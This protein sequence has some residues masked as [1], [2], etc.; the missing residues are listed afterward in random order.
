M[1][2]GFGKDGPITR[3]EIEN[4]TVAM[5]TLPGS[6]YWMKAPD[7]RRKVALGT[8]QFQHLKNLGKFD[9]GTDPATLGSSRIRIHAWW[10][11]T[12]QRF[13]A[14]G[15]QTDKTTPSKRGKYGKVKK[16]KAG[17]T[18]NA[19]ASKLTKKQPQGCPS[20]AGGEHL[21]GSAQ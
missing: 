19:R 9:G 3:R 20:N 14:P 8:T 13:I 17:S 2:L 6:P 10:N 7:Y 1:N 21:P 5:A 11:H 12:L 16:D 15:I 4:L 18:A